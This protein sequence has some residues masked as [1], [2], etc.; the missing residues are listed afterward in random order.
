MF[1]TTSLVLLLSGC[2]SEDE[3]KDNPTLAAPIGVACIPSYSG[4]VGWWAGDGNSNDQLGINNGQEMNGVGYVSG[5]VDQSFSFDGIDDYIT[6]PNSV[7]L[8]PIS[9]ITLAVWVKLSATGG[10]QVLVSKFYGNFSNEPN[11]DSYALNITPS[12]NLGFQVET[13]T[14]GSLRDNILITAPVDIYD[15]NYHFIVGKYDGQAMKIYYDGKEVTSIIRSPG[16]V[17]GDIQSSAGTPLLV[18][19]GSNGGADAWFVSGFLD[20]INIYTQSVLELGI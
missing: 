13:I 3:N 10:H 1:V 18:G 9:E 14:N 16:V 2:G 20:E 5:L 8:N 7:E 11:D 19:A 15:G 17:S 6:I 4:L 12:K